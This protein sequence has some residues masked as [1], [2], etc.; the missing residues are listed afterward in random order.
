MKGKD[1]LALAYVIRIHFMRIRILSEF[2]QTTNLPQIRSWFNVDGENTVASLKISLCASVPALRGARIRATELVLT[3][4]DFELLDDSAIDI[5]RDEDLIWYVYSHVSYHLCDLYESLRRRMQLA[6]RRAE[7]TEDAPRKRHQPMPP[8]NTAGVMRPTI[9]DYVRNDR[10]HQVIG[11][12]KSTEPSSSS[13][14]DSSSD[15]SSDDTSSDSG[16]TSGSSSDS[17]SDS[18]STS[19]SSS[20]YLPRIPRPLPS[21]AP[22]RKPPQPTYVT[23]SLL[24]IS[25]D[26]GSSPQACPSTAR[27]WEATD[28]LA[29]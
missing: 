9:E 18:D 1:E 11:R 28:P 3:L 27:I 22:Q 8:A 16:S 26:P 17:D 25:S 7:I 13:S 2:E 10:N 20:D 6:K 15:T 14:S 12:R 19:S 24:E 5:L 4:D 29:K 21:S 23:L